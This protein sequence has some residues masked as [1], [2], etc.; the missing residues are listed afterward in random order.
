MEKL[1]FAKDPGGGTLAG[2]PASENWAIPDNAN[3]TNP[4]FCYLSTSGTISFAM[5]AGAT[6]TTID[7]DETVSVVTGHKLYATQPL[8]VSTAGF[9]HIMTIGTAS[10][11]FQISPMEG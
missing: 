5:A 3:S 10:E 9:S 1:R 8:L 11:V 4:K 6:P 7:G 2:A